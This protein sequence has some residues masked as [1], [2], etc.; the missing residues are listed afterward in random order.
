MNGA[1]M[2]TPIRIRR[3]IA[4][5]LRG[6]PT[7][8]TTLYSFDGAGDDVALVFGPPRAQTPWVRMHSACLTGDLFGSQRCDCG[9]QLRL[10]I[11]H[12]T[13]HG[14]VLLYLGQEGRGLGL[15]AKIDA[16]ALQDAGLDTFEANLA[17]GHPVD[18]RDYAAAAGMLRALGHTRIR[19]LSANPDKRRQLEAHGVE[20]ADV[21]A[22]RVPPNPHNAGYLTAKARWFDAYERKLAE[23]EEAWVEEIELRT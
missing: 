5:P 7:L 17:L 10:S 8:R 18:A 19:L 9:E 2:S 11:A 16:Y 6:H 23:A 20:V 15:K 14:G 13:T 4:L 3:Q 21:Q 12:L 1:R 22:V